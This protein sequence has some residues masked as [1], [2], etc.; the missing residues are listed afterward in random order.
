[1][2]TRNCWLRALGACLLLAGE[3]AHAGA[4]LDRIRAS[5]QITFAH[6]ESSVPFSYLDANKRPVGY[7]IDICLR[8]AE[9]VRREIGAKALTPRFLMVTPANRIQSIAEGKADLECGSTT[10]NAERRKSVAFTVPHYIAGARLLVRAD[11]KIDDVA[12]LNG[13]RVVS[14]QG[15]TPLKALQQLGR[16]RLLDFKI[17]E[18]PEHTRGVEMVE[19]GEAEAFVMDDV[20][21]YGLVASRPEPGKLKVVGK[22]VTVEPLAIMLSKDDADFKRIVDDEMKR[23]IRSREINPIYDRWFLSPIPPRN[24]ALNLPMSYL[25]KDFWKVPTDVVWF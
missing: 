5:G 25:L 24:T 9:A 2:R 7:A 22:Y 16:D 20:L 15:T 14:T 3:A 17:A 6:R 12:Q 21:L 23:L 10:N 1:M 8:L 4:V 13:K 18:V 11:A 19:R